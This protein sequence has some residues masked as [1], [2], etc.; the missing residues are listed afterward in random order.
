MQG[1]LVLLFGETPARVDAIG[2]TQIYLTA[3]EDKED[4]H[5]GHPHVQPIP[6]TPEILEKNGFV[7]RTEGKVSRKSHQYVREGVYVS[8]WR[9]RLVVRHKQE[10]GRPSQ[11]MNVDCHFVHELQRALRMAGIEKEVVL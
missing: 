8:W 1:D 4:W 11:Y 6:V 3:L 9:Q 5:V 7:Q 10:T 2:D